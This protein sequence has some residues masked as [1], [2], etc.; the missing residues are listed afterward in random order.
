MEKHSFIERFYSWRIKHI[1]D[2]QFIMLLSV[3]IG[4]MS[5]MAA[6]FIKNS[7]HFIQH[8][9]TGW[10][11]DDAYNYL[12]IALPGIGILLVMIFIKFILK[13]GIG[14]GVPNVLY[15]I[16]KTSGLMKPHNI[17]SSVIASAITVGFGGSVGLEGPTVATG[18]A[19]G[20]N[21]GRVLHLNYKQIVSLLGFASAGAM[22]AIFKAPIAAIVFALEVIM[23][24]LT[25]ASLVPLL[26]ASVTAALTSYF[27]LGQ[28]VLYPFEVTESF[29]LS[30][31]LMYILLG[32][33]T[34]FVSVYFIRIMDYFGKFFE[35]LASWWVRLALG[36]SVLGL[37][38]FLFPSLYGE[39]Y[40]SINLALHGDY[41]YIFEQSIFYDYRDNFLIA[42]G[43]LLVISLLK[44]VA[45]SATFGSGGVG[46]IFAPTLFTGANF[47]LF[48]ALFMNHFHLADIPVTNFALVGM[49]GMIAGVIRGPLTAIFLIAEISGGYELIMPLMIV[50]TISYASSKL[51]ETDSVYT[52]QLAK[53]IDLITHHKDKAVLSLM[54][55]DSLIE[56]N[57]MT[58]NPNATLGDLVKVI[59]DSTRNIYPVIDKDQN[60]KGLIFLD[61]VRHIMFNH[62]MYGK[63][64]VKNLMFM[65]TT[66]VNYEDKMEEV[67]HKFQHSGKYNLVVL[68]DGK[69]LGFVSRANVFSKYRELLK[70]ISEH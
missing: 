59:A 34:G 46:G 35:G 60:L 22:A 10:T 33:F 63:V 30:H 24:D 31:V 41:Q 19:I 40:R 58:I 64:L 21:T 9:L 62:E 66:I 16:S 47:G 39:G 68:K 25:M 67:A 43:L 5:G 36:A 3:V 27:F 37:L 42:I 17:Y 50:S 2:K 32:V 23:L 38:L 14:D 70:D 48:F 1:T 20:S 11:N 28:N 57:F 13:Q 7:V 49:A 29:K 45:A 44:A 8:F 69:Y 56:T 65:P 51:F 15:S 55:I 4:F 54:N 18:A 26:L 52:I 12:Y 6:V 61:R 53:K